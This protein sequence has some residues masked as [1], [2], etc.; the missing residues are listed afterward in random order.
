MARRYLYLHFVFFIKNNLSKEVVKKEFDKHKLYW[1]KFER[2]RET[3][4]RVLRVSVLSMFDE[5][6]RLCKIRGKIA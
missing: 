4:T 5:K 3:C 2:N 6:D 1:I